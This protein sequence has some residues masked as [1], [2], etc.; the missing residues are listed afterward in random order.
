MALGALDGTVRKQ[1][2]LQAYGDCFFLIG[3]TLCL[4]VTATFAAKRAVPTGGAAG[5]H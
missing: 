5:A 3:V 1:A 2:Y 4:A